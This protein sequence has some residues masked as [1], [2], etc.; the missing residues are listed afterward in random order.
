MRFA[1]NLSNTERRVMAIFLNMKKREHERA[2]LQIEYDLE[3]LEKLG[4]NIY[5]LP[6]W[7]EVIIDEVP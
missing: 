3:R 2:I 6:D 1:K 7:G 5:D 4:V